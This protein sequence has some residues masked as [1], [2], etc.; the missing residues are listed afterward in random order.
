LHG[1]AGPEPEAQRW[2]RAS[3]WR[4][5]CSGK[6]ELRAK[7][8]CPSSEP[9]RTYSS[10]PSLVLVGIDLRVTVLLRVLHSDHSEL[11]SGAQ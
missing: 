3:A 8:T 9:S 6:L 7:H 1:N 11:A 4:S 2:S 5:G 10:H